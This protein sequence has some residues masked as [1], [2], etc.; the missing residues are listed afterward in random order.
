MSSF[1]LDANSQDIFLLGLLSL[2]L[3][4]FRSSS[5]QVAFLL[6]GFPFRTFPFYVVLL[7]GH[8]YFMSFSIYVV[9]LLDRL[10][11]SSSSFWV[12]FHFRSSSFLLIFVVLGLLLRIDIFVCKFPQMNL[13]P[14]ELRQNNINSVL[15]VTWLNSTD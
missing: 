13:T 11:F 6:G 14:G 4:P 10:P 8:L 7:L 1:S 15:F 3:L 12:I 9:F 5:F 2:G